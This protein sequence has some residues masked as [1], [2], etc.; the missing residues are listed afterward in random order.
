MGCWPHRWHRNELLSSSA[1][2]ILWPAAPVDQ[3]DLARE[4]WR[5]KNGCRPADIAAEGR[6]FLVTL[7]MVNKQ[8]LARKQLEDLN[9][10][11]CDR[12]R[13]AVD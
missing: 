8:Q 1:R 6:L 4:E 5:A 9:R 13:L 3:I 11:N 7:S 10:L 2:N 12:R